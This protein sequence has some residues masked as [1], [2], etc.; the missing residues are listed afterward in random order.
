MTPSQYTQLTQ[1]FSRLND[2]ICD[3]YSDI[4]DILPEPRR[5]TA[6]YG[7]RATL[8]HISNIYRQVSDELYESHKTI[9]KS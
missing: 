7:L 6:V 3:F 4:I 1:I 5:H 9:D 8:D 2:A